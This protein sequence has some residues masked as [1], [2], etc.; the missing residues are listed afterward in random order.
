M[1]GGVLTEKIFVYAGGGCDTPIIVIHLCRPVTQSARQ[2]GVG[3]G[4][5][6]AKFFNDGGKIWH[7]V[8]NA[9]K[10]RKLQL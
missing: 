2:T 5:H 9:A 4:G 1:N 8:G 6:L 3:C 10:R 7:D